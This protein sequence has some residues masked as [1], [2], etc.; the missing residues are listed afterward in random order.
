MNSNNIKIAIRMTN[1]REM[2]ERIVERVRAEL[3]SPGS[4]KF[5]FCSSNE[6][7]ASAGSDVA[8]ASCY[9]FTPEI[10]SGLSGLKW[11]HFGATGVDGILFPKLIESD[12]ILTKAVGFHSKVTAE[13]AFAMMLYFER[14]FAES[15]KFRESKKWSQREIALQNGTLRGKSLGILG[16][17]AVGQAL[18]EMANVFGMNVSVASRS[19]KTSDTL[20]HVNRVYPLPEL[21]ELIA[22][23]DYFAVCVPLTIETKGLINRENLSFMKESAIII[24]VARGAIIDESALY[25]A[26]SQKKIAGA[27]LDVFAVEPLPEDSPLFELDNVFLSPHIA[28]NFGNYTPL[29]ATDFGLNLQRYLSGKELNNVVNKSL[30]Y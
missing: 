10:L 1:H 22:Q 14:K 20:P 26:L 17:G 18:A 6:E 23:S 9:K 25:Q 13:H 7:F 21:N 30:G 5:I 15:I 16:F 24:N 28:G 2:F 27:G 12:V 19:S 3:D 11:L 29:A 8:V 4:V